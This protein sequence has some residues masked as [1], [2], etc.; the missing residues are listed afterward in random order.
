MMSERIGGLMP[1]KRDHWWEVSPATDDDALATKLRNAVV[2]FGLPWLA[3]FA[4]PDVAAERTG[5]TTRPLVQA[6]LQFLK[7]N[8][9]AAIAVMTTAIAENPRG[10]EYWRPF[11]IATGLEAEFRA[12]RGLS[13]G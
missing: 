9:D 13:N 1:N 4:D 8:R 11:A 3:K 5:P 10:V 12:A 2:E 6:E 7:G